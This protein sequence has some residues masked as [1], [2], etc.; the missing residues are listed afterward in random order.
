MLL[1]TEQNEDQRA[2]KTAG[3]ETREV[4]TKKAGARPG[5]RSRP[6]PF[7]RVLGHPRRANLARSPSLTNSARPLESCPVRLDSDAGGLFIGLPCLEQNL[8]RSPAGFETL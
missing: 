7:G 2:Y 1:A 4:L 3:C 6:I 8:L 5:L